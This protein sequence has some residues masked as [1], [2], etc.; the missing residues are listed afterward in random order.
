MKKNKPITD[1][2]LIEILQEE[3]NKYGI[4]VYTDRRKTATEMLR[5]RGVKI[6]N[7]IK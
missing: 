5:V 6:S 2:R 1:E 7:C 4:G 3:I